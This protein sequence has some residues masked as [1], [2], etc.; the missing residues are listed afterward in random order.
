[1]DLVDVYVTVIS[2]LLVRVVVDVVRRSVGI[3]DAP[4]LDA[5]HKTGS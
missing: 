4:S 2:V 3:A 5:T 1:M